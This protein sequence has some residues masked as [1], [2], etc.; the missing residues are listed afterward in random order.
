MIVLLKEAS[1]LIENLFIL[2]H[3]DYVGNKAI[4]RAYKQNLKNGG[5]ISYTDKTQKKIEQIIQ[6]FKYAFIK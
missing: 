2:S 3:K 4:K 6:E 1:E 5:T